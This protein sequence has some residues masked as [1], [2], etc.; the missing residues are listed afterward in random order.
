MLTERQRALYEKA[1]YEKYG[2]SPYINRQNSAP[3]APREDRRQA[4]L[5]DERDRRLRE[6]AEKRRAEAERLRKEAEEARL[7]AVRE[8]KRRQA[9]EREIE[10]KKR[11]LSLRDQFRHLSYGSY[12]HFFF[13]PGL[14]DGRRREQHAV[15]ISLD[16]LYLIVRKLFTYNVDRVTDVPWA[17]V[18]IVTVGADELNKTAV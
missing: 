1:Y 6:A 16:D 2:R 4:F 14:S 13:P 8:E 17:I 9:L 10:K 5:A 12:F 11:E 3:K 18:R 7:A 15:R